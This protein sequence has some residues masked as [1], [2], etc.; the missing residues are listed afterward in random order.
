MRRSISHRFVEFIPERLENGVLYIS[1]EYA[2]VAHK[3]LCG[4]GKE[5]VTPLSPTDW[6][7]TYD[8]ETVSLDPSVGNWS[9]PHYWIRQSRVDWCGDMP[10]ALIDAG[11]AR[12][13]RHKDAYYATRNSGAASS[14]P[15]Q[16]LAL[17]VRPVN[18][19]GGFLSRVFD[20]LRL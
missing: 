8:G 16:A 10:Q 7:L 4:C 2:T 9:F 5:V 20:W 18:T 19:R 14:S 15:S 3:C 1:T 6:T 17:E 13:R 11:R 12:D